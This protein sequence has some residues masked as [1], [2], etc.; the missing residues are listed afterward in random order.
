MTGFLDG[1]NDSLKEQNPIERR[2]GRGH[3][4]KPWALTKE[5]PLLRTWHG[6]EAD[7]LYDLPEWEYF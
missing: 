3:R 5:L 2:D 1:I 7:W 6:Y 4:S